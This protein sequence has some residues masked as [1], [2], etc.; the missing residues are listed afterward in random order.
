MSTKGHMLDGSEK[1]LFIKTFQKTE[2]PSA[3]STTNFP[4]FVCAWSS[5]LPQSTGWAA[6]QQLPPGASQC[7][8]GV[9]QGGDEVCSRDGN[10]IEVSDKST[11]AR[12]MSVTGKT[13]YG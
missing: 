2:L 13:F 1:V 12:Q 3:S 8:S 9:S 6:K 11:E 7:M 4:S 10:N 5:L